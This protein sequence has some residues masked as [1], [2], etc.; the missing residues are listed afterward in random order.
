MRKLAFKHFLLRM[1]FD[2]VLE[3][4]R[5]VL[6]LVIPVG[7]VV[8]GIYVMVEQIFIVK[9]KPPMMAYSLG[10]VLVIYGLFRLYRAFKPSK[11]S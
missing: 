2:E 4:L 5:F 7:Y 6:S 3:K 8:L 9:I 1:N 11:E 10:A